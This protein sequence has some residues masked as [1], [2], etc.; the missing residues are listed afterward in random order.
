M[1]NRDYE[2]KEGFRKTGISVE[3]KASYKI[4]DMT[5]E[6]LITD[7]SEGGVALR[8][9]QAFSVGDIVVIQSDISNNLTLRFKGEVRNVDGNIVGAMIL[10]I[11]IPSR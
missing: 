6:A 4:R 7:I 11:V 3:Y 9:R 2:M 8:V 5:G 1:A 10:E